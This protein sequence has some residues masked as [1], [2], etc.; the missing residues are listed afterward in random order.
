MKDVA[1]LVPALYSVYDEVGKPLSISSGIGT[2]IAEIAEMIAKATKFT[3]KIHYDRS[4]GDGQLY[5]VIS[6]KKL[7]TILE[8]NNIEWNLTPIEEAIGK[9]V[10]WF[11]SRVWK[12]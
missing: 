6:N 1:K 3:G 10:E 4:F 7:L 8:K 12:K 2:S 11:E 5:K 9:T